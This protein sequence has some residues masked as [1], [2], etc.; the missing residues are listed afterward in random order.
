V[1]S[2][3]ICVIGTLRRK[4]E[5]S[6]WAH[7]KER[8]DLRM[9]YMGAYRKKLEMLAAKHAGEDYSPEVLKGITARAHDLEM[10]ID[11]ED[12]MVYRQRAENELLSAKR[13]AHTAAAGHAGEKEE[14][15]SKKGDA[16]AWHVRA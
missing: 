7:L 6:S 1:A 10:K 2:A 11:V 16:H 4:S 14:T 8:R 9:A 12:L 15:P 3:G 5:T 13:L